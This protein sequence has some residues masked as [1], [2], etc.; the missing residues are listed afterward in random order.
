[1]PPLSTLRAKTAANPNSVSNGGNNLAPVISPENLVQIPPPASLDLP[2]AMP[3]RGVFP[4]SNVMVSDRSDSTRVFR[5]QNMRSSVFQNPAQPTAT[6]IAAAISTPAAVAA[7]VEILVNNQPTASQSILNFVNSATVQF[8]AGANG[9]ISATAAAATGDGLIHLEPNLYSGSWESDPAYVILRDDFTNSQG[10][11][12]S[13][14]PVIAGIGQ[15]GWNLDGV[16]TSAHT[17]FAGGIPPYLG[18]FYWEN[19][20]TANNFGFLRLEQN[21]NQGGQS[22][23]NFGWA[24]FDNPGWQETWIFR[25]GSCAPGAGVVPSFAGTAMYIGFCGT[26]QNEN[27]SGNPCARPEVFFGV[28]YDTS[29]YI[30]NP[31]T[32][33]NVTANAQSG[34]NMVLT[35]TFTGANSTTGTSWVGLT[36]TTTN[37]GLVANNGSFVCTAVTSSTSITLYNPNGVTESGQTA[38]AIGSTP[39]VMTA[40]ANGNGSTV[41]YTGT[42][43]GGGT[44][45]YVGQLFY[46]SGFGNAGNNGGPWKCTACN[47]VAGTITLANPL[48]T[49]SAETHAGYIG[50][51]V[52]NDATLTLEAVVNPSYGASGRNNTQGVT[53]S[54]V[55]PVI[56]TWHRLDVICSGT[57][58]ITIVLDD[59]YILTTPVAQQ[60]VTSGTNQLEGNVAQNQLILSWTVTPGSVPASFWAT[61][62]QVTVAGFSGA[63]AG[64]D[65]TWTVLGNDTVGGSVS[66][67]IDY[68]AAST[69]AQAGVSGTIKGYPAIYPCAIFGSANMTGT[70]ST[71]T[72]WIDFFSFVWNPG[73][74]A[75]GGTPVATN[76]RGW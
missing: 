64:F 17:G 59:T 9:Q 50:S 21:G 72:L 73:L 76:P 34:N 38:H 56:G 33:Y 23:A 54:T 40:A 8:Q 35:G 45:N 1:M 42:I 74:S 49:G 66:I 24:L 4:P 46:V 18:Q 26:Q 71:A 69:I 29:G 20:G 30:G 51:P 14:S 48:T 28:R 7:A 22:G 44:N 60:T 75:A 55:A 47:A 31:S 3:Q 61:G 58:S 10:T 52:L 57:G 2:V 11:Q 68:P 36:F 70:L 53:L 41:T 63:Q 12:T 27:I 13:T 15:L 67:I 5:N 25:L 32:S 16:V 37:F 39:M 6:Q 65:S 19:N 43:T 62:S